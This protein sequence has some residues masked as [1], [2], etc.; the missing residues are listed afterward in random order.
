MADLSIQVR[1][2]GGAT[3]ARRGG[4]RTRE[5]SSNLSNRNR[6]PRACLADDQQSAFAS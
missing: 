5:M 2:A 4:I 6:L 3:V 1:D